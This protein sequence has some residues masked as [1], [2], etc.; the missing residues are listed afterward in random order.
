MI[1]HFTL[2]STNVIVNNIDLFKKFKNNIYFNLF[3]KIFK[4]ENKLKLKNS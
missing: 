3:K 2:L 4:R 1:G